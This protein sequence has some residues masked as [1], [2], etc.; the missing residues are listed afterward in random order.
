MAAIDTD[1]TGEITYDEF[2]IFWRTD[3]RFEKLRLDERKQAIIMQLSEYYRYFDDDFS[4]ELDA[5]EFRELYDNLLSQVRILFQGE[6]GHV[7]TLH[8]QPR[9]IP[10]GQFEC[11]SCCCVSVCNGQGYSLG[12]FSS[13]LAHVDR[14]GD[15]KIA[16]NEFISWM[17]SLGVLDWT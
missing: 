5:R 6:N 8:K 12:D 14:S 11:Q 7:A 10:Q 13:T 9:K 3:K 2:L 15:G 16:F 4:G 17:V 1:G